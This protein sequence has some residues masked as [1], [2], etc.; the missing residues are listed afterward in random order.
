V[1]TRYQ[2]GQKKK[3]AYCTLTYTRSPKSEEFQEESPAAPI[4]FKNL[5][6]VSHFL[7]I[8]PI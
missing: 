1:T 4:P 8:L 7:P 5:L 2:R 3:S 6:K